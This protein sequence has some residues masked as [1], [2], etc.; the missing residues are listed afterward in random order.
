M[1]QDRDAEKL[2]KDPI[3]LSVST[4]NSLR[5]RANSSVAEVVIRLGDLSGSHRSRGHLRTN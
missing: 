5:A 2:G 1:P 3:P 4:T